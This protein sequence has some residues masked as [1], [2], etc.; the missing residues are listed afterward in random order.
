MSPPAGSLI[1]FA[2]DA[3]HTAQDG[4]GENGLYTGEL[5]KHLRTPGL[6]VEQV[7]KRTRAGVMDASG[8]RQVPAEYSRL[9]GEDVFLAGTLSGLRDKS[10]PSMPLAVMAQAESA[11]PPSRSETLQWAREGRYAEVVR[12][13]EDQVA[14]LGPGTHAHEPLQAILESVKDLLKEAK[15]PS[16]AVE[17]AAVACERVLNALPRCL[18]LDDPLRGELTARAHSRRG[19]A[20]MI[21]GLYEAALED[22]EQA[23]LLL[24]KDAYVR[25]NRAMAWW[26]LGQRA[27]AKAELEAVVRD[28]ARQPGARRLALQELEKM[29]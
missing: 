25:Y 27:E 19:D 23:L 26:A 22:Y 5:L 13:V 8:G 15:E 18:A 3:G 14:D 16:P 6:T 10:S 2:T 29:K 24:P 1:A 28:S 9:V 11:E 12:A 17:A 20:R 7:F 4:E 21:L